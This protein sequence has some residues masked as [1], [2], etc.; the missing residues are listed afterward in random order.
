MLGY[1]VLKDEQYHR[2]V[3]AETH[4]SEFL[5]LVSSF[6]RNVHTL[7]FHP[8]TRMFKT[9][10]VGSDERYYKKVLLSNFRLIFIQS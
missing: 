2:K 7:G 9:D 3:L 5:V 10:L 6:H 8:Q 4:I 1:P